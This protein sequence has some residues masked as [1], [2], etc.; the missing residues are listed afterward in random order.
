MIQVVVRDRSGNYVYDPEEFTQY[1]RGVSFATNAPGGYAD[2]SMT[3]MRRE[4]FSAWAI[5]EG[6]QVRLYDGLRLIYEGDI[7]DVQAKS[8]GAITVQCSG[9]QWILGAVQLAKLW[10][11]DAVC[12]E[13]SATGDNA[14]PVAEP[15]D[16]QIGDTYIRCTFTAV[17]TSGSKVAD[18]YRYYARYD[19]RGLGIIR[20]VEGVMEFRLD[21]GCRC[22]IWN[23]DQAAT[24]AT[25]TG[26]NP[27]ITQTSI[28]TTLTQGATEALTFVLG[29]SSDSLDYAQDDWMNIRD[30][31]VKC[32]YHASHPNYASPAYT[33]KQLL[34]DI[35]YES[36]LISGS[37][38]SADFSDV[39]DPGLTISPFGGR[40]SLTVAKHIDNV[41]AFGDASDQIYF[42]YVWGSDGSSDGR[43]QFAVSARD[44]SDY[45]YVADS[46]DPNVRSIDITYTGQKL[47]NHYSVEYTGP[48]GKPYLL[49]PT[50]NSNLK[51]QTSIDTEFRRDEVINIGK[52]SAALAGQIGKTQRL[53]YDSRRLKG[54][55]DVVH[56]IL[57]KDGLYVPACWVRAGQRVYLPELD[58]IIFIG[59]TNYDNE[60]GVLQITPDEE[61]DT[62]QAILARNALSYEGK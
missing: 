3:F 48:D 54:S 31:I 30:L 5:R 39:N 34:L 43:P 33:S 59:S 29:P 22:I 62:L 51:N 25:F 36:G 23:D 6:Y 61:P 44:V 7:Q 18:D 19:T 47:K 12:S 28:N 38:I 2:A 11:D 16:V 27:V 52:S 21:E 50:A 55:I 56:E 42:W 53:K 9:R 20:R 17:D 26:A 13:F 40:K 58:E 4:P 46:R 60:T 41:L 8:D 14:A 37:I 45:E 49:T 57:R 10:I 35:L 24:E 32:H 15:F 1:V